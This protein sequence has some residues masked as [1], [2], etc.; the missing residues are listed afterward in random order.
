MNYTYPIKEFLSLTE[1]SKQKQLT[2]LK[3]RQLHKRLNFVTQKYN[4]NLIYKESN[5]WYIHRSL[6]K[7]F[8]RIKFLIDYK[9]FVTISS[10][11]KFDVEY[12][13]TFVN[14]FYKELKAIDNKVRLKYVIE[15]NERELPHLHFMT[16]YSNAKELR[17][18]LRN[19]IITSDENGMN[20][21]VKDVNKVEGLHKYFRKQNKPVLLR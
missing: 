16:T 18:R 3:Y 10:R 14:L 1:L 20:R 4:S 17:K 6:I 8:K 13:R 5:I 9:L 11:D 12:W 19:N 7:D 2:D 21:K 15:Y